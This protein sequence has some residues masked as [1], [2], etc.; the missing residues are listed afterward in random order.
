MK[1]SKLFAI[2]LLA[3]AMGAC[4]SSDDASDSKT[5]QSSASSSTVSSSTASSTAEQSTAYKVGETWEV[6]GQWKLTVN[7]IT[8]TDERNPDDTTNPAAVYLIDY[9]YT[10]EGFQEKDN[11]ED[12]LYMNLA[13]AQIVD[14][15]GNMSQSYPAGDLNKLPQST[16]VRATDADAQVAVGVSEPGTVTVHVDMY[17]GDG[18][19]Q[20]AVFELEPAQ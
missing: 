12:G 17:D 3:F 5:S 20:K 9:T 7:S 8:P 13:M 6:P 18:N 4:A 15:A 14:A 11:M 1:I 16:P 2:S 10:N 19:P